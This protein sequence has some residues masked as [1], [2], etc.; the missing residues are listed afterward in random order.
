MCLY[1]LLSMRKSLPRHRMLSR[2]ALLEGLPALRADQLKGGAF[3]YDAQIRYPE[4]LTVEN[5]VDARRHGAQVMTHTR[6][7]RVVCEPGQVQGGE[8]LGRGGQGGVAAARAV[9]NAGGAWVDRVL[10]P[11]T[12][13]PLVGGT[14]GSHI[15][16]EPFPGAPGAALYAEASFDGRPF[17]VLP[18]ND[19]YLIGTTDERFDGDPG[20]AQID[21]CE[22]AYLITETENL[23]PEASG[24]ADKVLY[25]QSGIRP[26]PQVS[27]RSTGA[28]GSREPMCLRKAV[29]NRPG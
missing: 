1:D 3:Y 9:V 16:V 5:L 27:G 6:V 8:W 2:Q 15:V 7:T 28:T 17:F 11:L 21:P 20:T 10:G 23:L 12:S 19:L 26:L 18:W 13:A 29:T 25:T 24:L 14:K 22:F 4:R